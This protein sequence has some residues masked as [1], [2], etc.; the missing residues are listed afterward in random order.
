MEKH[1][2]AYTYLKPME[3][4]ID[5]YDLFT[6][7]ECLD[8]IRFYQKVYKEK[9]THEDL[10]KV[11]AEEILRGFSMVLNW[12]LYAT[13]GNR[14]KHKKE[15]IQEWINRDQKKQDKYD[16]TL[17]PT[18]NCPSCKTPMESFDKTL[19]HTTNDEN[20]RMLFFFKCPSCDKRAGVYDTGEIRVSKPYLCPKCNKEATYTHKEQGKISKWTTKCKSCGYKNEEIDDFEKKR[21]EWDKKE[22]EDK[23]L[24]EK[25]RKEYCLDEKEGEEC[26][27]NVEA[28]EYTKFAKEDEI[29]IYDNPA[30]EALSHIRKIEINELES[31]LIK[32]LV[33]EKFANISFEKPELAQ[34]VTVPFTTQNSAQSRNKQNAVNDI[35]NLIK[36]TLKDTNWRLTSEG[37]TNRLGYLSGSLRG[38]ETEDDL[39]K[40]AGKAKPTKPPAQD[41]ERKSKLESHPYVQLTRLLAKMEARDNIRNRRLEKEPNGYILNEPDHN[42]PCYVCSNNTDGKAWWD[43]WG[44]KCLDCQKNVDEGVIPPEVAKNKDMWLKDWDFQSDYGVHPATRDKLVRQGFIKARKLKRADGINYFTVYLIDENKEFFD[45]YPKMPKQQQNI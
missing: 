15:R 23:D 1:Q 38:Y 3:C 22:Q 30:Y 25:H 4:Y 20:L 10:K 42:Y 11:P 31:L 40:L 5:L 34:N 27:L 9:S 32:S 29:G 17:E 44:L 21:A 7:N 39:I 36:E 45:K 18:Y 6:I 13:K 26:L 33:R 8:L 12:S 24:L 2:E 28:M 16:N 43:K 19:D 14:Y 37:I 41:L 35:E